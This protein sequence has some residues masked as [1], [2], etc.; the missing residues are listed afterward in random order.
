M[1]C[2]TRIIAR[3]SRLLQVAQHV[4]HL[5]LHDHVERGHRL[6]GDHQRGLQRQRERDRGA[7]AHAA[8]ELVRIVG[9]PHRIEADQAHQLLGARHARRPRQAAALAQHLQHLRAQPL[10]RIERIH[11]GLRHERHA[12][13]AQRAAFAFGQGDEVAALEHDAAAGDA[14]GAGQHAHQRARRGW[15]CRSRSRRPGPRCCRRGRRD[16]RHP[17]RARCRRRCV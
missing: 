6:V 9:Q 3:F 11:R 15:I 1:S 14:A 4:E 2:V 13:P 5:A 7:L 17:P 8:A 12:A 16:R 10:H